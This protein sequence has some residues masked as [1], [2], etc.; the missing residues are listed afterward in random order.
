MIETAIEEGKY[1]KA[2]TNL[3]TILNDCKESVT[4]ICLKIECLMKNFQFFEANE[5]SRIVQLTAKQSIINNPNFLMWRGKVL[6]YNGQ[7]E[8][9]KKHLL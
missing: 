9:G 8:N 3:T 7:Q 2:V 1:D 6:I 4:H 5:F